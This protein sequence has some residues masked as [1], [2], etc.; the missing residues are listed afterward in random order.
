VAKTALKTNRAPRR[1]VPNQI[2]KKKKISQMNRKIL[3]KRKLK[4]RSRQ[5]NKLKNH[6]K[7]QKYHGKKG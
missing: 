6:Y 2:A 3:V 7:S 5:L 4:K 1:I